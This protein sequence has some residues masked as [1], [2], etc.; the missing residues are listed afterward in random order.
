LNREQRSMT[1]K[2]YRDRREAVKRARERS[3]IRSKTIET[4]AHFRANESQEARNA[5]V[6]FVQIFI[7]PLLINS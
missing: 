7:Y 4:D 2:T 3:S 5:E 1:G 6:L